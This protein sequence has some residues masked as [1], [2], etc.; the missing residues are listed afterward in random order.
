MV[1]NQLS[2]PIL[3]LLSCLAVAYVVEGQQTASRDK[4]NPDARVLQDFQDRIKK[5]VDLRKSLEKKGPRLKETAEPAQIRAAQDALAQNIQAARKTAR[6]GDIF[7]PEIRQAFRRLMY[8]EMKGREGAE[9]KAV[10]KEDAPAPASVP[11]K[12][13][14]KYPEDEPLPTVPANLLA[15]LPELPEGLEYRIVRKDLILRDSDANLIV[16]FIPNAI[17]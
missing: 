6:P 11:L 10:I 9:T 15:A 14:S 13:N 5:Y 1:K 8:P 3:M 12:V 7:T 17:A 2:R 16:D 4:V